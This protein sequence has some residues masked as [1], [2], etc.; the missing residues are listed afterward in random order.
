M[1]E[2]PVSRKSMPDEETTMEFTRA[3]LLLLLVVWG[4]QT[5]AAW[6]QWRNFQRSLHR[7]LDTHRDGFL[8]IGKSR[9]P[10]GFGTVVLLVVDPQQRVRQLQVM[11]GVSVFAR[12]R[13]LP[14][15]QGIALGDLPSRLNGRSLPRRFLEAV[16]G[17]TT[18]IEQARQGRPNLQAAA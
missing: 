1:Y 6:V 12:F 9:P 13:D 5:M 10:L 11:S 18:Q 7:A 3:A 8:G 2:G 14:E 15:Y 16:R 4:L 17:A